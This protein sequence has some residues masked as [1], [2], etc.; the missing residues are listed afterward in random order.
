[1]CLQ[2]PKC[3]GDVVGPIDGIFLVYTWYSDGDRMAL[4]NPA[5][6]ELDA[7]MY[8]NQFFHRIFMPL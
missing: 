2:I 1:M 4:W 7:S 3:M 5:M 6:R 8:S